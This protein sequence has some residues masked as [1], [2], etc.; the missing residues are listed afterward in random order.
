MAS[1]MWLALGLALLALELV[2]PGSF[3]VMFFG[4]G[5]LTVGL[6][7]RL[8][9]A[10]PA[11]GHW[12]LFTGLSIG[13]LLIFR[14]KLLSGFDSATPRDIDSFVGAVAIAQERILPAQVGRVEIR[15]S[16]WQ[17]RNETSSPIEPGLR[18]R[19]V[20]VDGLMV[21]IQPE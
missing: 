16:T 8:D 7:A 10:G 13:Y 17:A 11:W 15:G 19:V 4:F 1:W 3:F 9:L 21:S 2:T 12:L 18:C 14:R 5:A 6:L 20:R